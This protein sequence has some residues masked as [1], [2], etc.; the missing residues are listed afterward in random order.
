MRVATSATRVNAI[1]PPVIRI[2][3]NPRGSRPPLSSNPQPDRRSANGVAQHLQ[4]DLCNTG[5]RHS[6]SPESA[7][8]LNA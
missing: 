2:R 3:S 8:A 6:R 4:A 5:L 1:C 7:R